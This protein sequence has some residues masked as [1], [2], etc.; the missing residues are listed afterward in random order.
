MPGQD[1]LLTAAY[2]GSSREG[3]PPPKDFASNALVKSIDEYKALYEESIADPERFWSREAGR[4]DWF[5]RFERV[6]A[7]SFDHDNV[8]IEWFVGGKLNASYN[9]IDR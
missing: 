9:C 6:S 5:K 1:D 7:T 3:I 4:L 8:S 2:S